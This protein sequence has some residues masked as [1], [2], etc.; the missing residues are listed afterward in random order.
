MRAALRAS[1]APV[2]FSHSNAR[3]LA[4]HARNVPDDV[5]RALPANG[6]V[7]MVTFVAWFV[8]GPFWVREDGKVGAS[9]VELADHVCHIVEV[10]TPPSRACCRARPLVGRAGRVSAAKRLI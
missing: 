7:V 8:A 5:L 10:R 1:T 4:A 9:V 3:L 2:L 6:G